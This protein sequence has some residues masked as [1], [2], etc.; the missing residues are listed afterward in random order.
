MKK[1]KFE[2][3]LVEKVLNGSKT[4]T[5]RLFDDKDLRIG[6]KLELIEFGTDEMFA[7]A[8]IVAVEEKSLGD[9]TE[10]DFK[11]HETFPSRDEMLATYRGYYGDKVNWDTVVKMVDFKLL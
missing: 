6:D 8:E 9:I 11:G 3:S 7:N 10:P 5:W 1:L 4:S 2:H